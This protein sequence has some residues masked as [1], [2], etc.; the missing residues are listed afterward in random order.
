M[1]SQGRRAVKGIPT[2]G[3]VAFAGMT[4]FITWSIFSESETRPEREF[5]L[6]AGHVI[7]AIP[8][9]DNPYE[10]ELEIERQDRG[11]LPLSGYLGEFTVA[12][13]VS[14]TRVNKLFGVET[15]S[16]SIH[17]NAYLV[18]RLYLPDQPTLDIIPSSEGRYNMT[19]FENGADVGIDMSRMYAAL[20]RPETAQ[21]RGDGLTCRNG[22]GDPQFTGCIPGV[23]YDPGI[24][25]R[26]PI[27]GANDDGH[28]ED[29]AYNVMT[30]Y[31]LVTDPCQIEFNWIPKLNQVYAEEGLPEI[32]GTDQASKAME[33]MVRYLLRSQVSPGIHPSMVDVNLVDKWTPPPPLE[34]RVKN[35][36]GAMGVADSVDPILLN[37]SELFCRER[38]ESYKGDMIYIDGVNS[39]G[40]IGV[41]WRL[42]ALMGMEQAPLSLDPLTGEL[43][44]TK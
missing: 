44:G 22:L 42:V 41:D 38:D 6:V 14:F 4:S 17:R 18:N 13:N 19:V 25:D 35:I 2:V 15:S 28:A 27:F 8:G 20:L 3:L 21:E 9:V 34:T 7:D 33:V 10:V 16:V 36:L 26:S 30:E 12:S 11:R 43:A 37:E 29:A 24:L 31:G 32:D 39:N 23:D 40:E 5:E 1:Y